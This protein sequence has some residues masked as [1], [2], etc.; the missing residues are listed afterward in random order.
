IKALAEEVTQRYD[1]YTEKV[2]SILEWLKFGEYRYSLKPGIAPDGDQLA[3]FLFNSKKGYCTYYAFAMTLM[4]RSLGIP[5]RVAAG[6]FIDPDTG[7]FDY[8]P[9]RSDMAHAWVE[10]PFPGCGWIE[11]DP[12]TED[13]AEGEEFSF[14][15]GID[16]QLLERL[17]REILENRS[18]L[19]VKMG[20]DDKSILTDPYSLVR[21]TA[22]FMKKLFAPL[23]II[24]VIIAFVILR[25][26]YLFLSLLC[27]GR[28]RKA[29]YLWK[30]TRR[31]LRLA[32]LG[33]P[34]LKTMSESEWALR[35]DSI[36]KGVYA[37][38]LGAA[39][40]RFAPEYQNEDFISMQ[41][42]YRFFSDSYRRAISFWRR[43]LAWIFPPAALFSGKK[44]AALLL[45]AFL[46]GADARAQ[47]GEGE[48][49]FTADELLHRAI[50]AEYSEYWERAIDLLKEGGTLY[51]DDIRFPRT[52]GRLY[53][54]RA[55]YGLAWDEYR[56]AEQINPYDTYVL[57]RLANTA[58]HLNHDKTSVAY[59][60]KLLAIDPDHREAISNLGWMYYKVHRPQDGERILVSAIERFGE[61]HDFAMT[62]AIVYSDMYRYDDG[63]YWYQKSIALSEFMRSFTA[64]AHYNLSILESRFYHYDLAM[65]AANASIDAQNRASGLLARGELNMRRLKLES[66]QVDFLAAQEIDPSPLAKLNLALVYLISGRLEEA[67]L[68]ALNCLKASDHSWMINYGIDPIRYKRD[69]HEILYQTYSGLAEAE[70][71]VPCETPIKKIRSIFRSIS[72]RFYS[73]VHRKLYQKYCLAA[74][75]A[76]RIVFS[77]EGGDFPP[78]EQLMQYFNAFETYPRRALF[79]LNKAEAFEAAIIPASVPSYNLEKG[80]LLKNRAMLTEALAGLDPLWESDLISE[81]YREFAR[82][83][84]RSRRQVAASELFALNRGALL[85]AGISLPVEIN[86]HNAGGKERLFRRTLAKAGFSA[87]PE[88]RFRL[89]IALS[90]GVAHCEI[91]DK[92]GEAGPLRKTIPLPSMSRTDIYSFAA[93]LGK[94]AFRVE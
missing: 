45:L 74:G 20:Q 49:N 42:A 27:R 12:T 3:W 26:G 6:F 39:A 1:G 36:V 15:S 43:F 4:L 68:Y 33:R 56:K 65:D 7:I 40:A 66:A 81:C 82:G 25:C 14:S 88:A 58:G 93:A 67:R 70:R 87:A 11:F 46:F 71:F 38:Y 72:F 89:D 76:Y 24:S 50:E 80:V 35:I 44:L 13:L 21:L 55:L 9:V 59:L 28:R 32:G 19:K 34:A 86:L 69:I 52:L 17:M 92:E 30:H 16:P 75:D 22:A 94:F 79:Y 90:G 57:L 61:D 63:K 62:L 48:N 77:G 8:Y 31:R 18:R 73:T 83:W 64:V 23:L 47:D 37:M 91:I 60:E 10:V 78:L 29:V 53:Y 51:P 5:A 85:Q 41:N 84:T 2:Y 54:S